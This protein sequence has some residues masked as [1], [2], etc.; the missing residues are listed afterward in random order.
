MPEFYKQEL[1]KKGIFKD[2]R[3]YD[4]LKIE[5]E[6]FGTFYKTEYNNFINTIDNIR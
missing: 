6:R 5:T 4:L 1:I 3:D 2:T